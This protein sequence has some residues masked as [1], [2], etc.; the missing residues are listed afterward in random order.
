MIFVQSEATAARRRFPV[1]LVDA[2]DGIT[3]ETG[4]AGGQSQIS[5]NGG[6]FANT[7]ATLTAIGNGAYYVELTATELDTAGDIIVR[8]KSAN[9]AEFDAP[10]DV[11]GSNIHS[12][13]PA[14]NVTQWLGATPN[15]L[16]SGRVDASVGAMA[17]NV[18]TAAA[19]AGDFSTE[20]NSPI[21]AVLG[22]LADAAAD[23]DPTSADTLMQ[24]MKQLVNVL[25]GTAGVV[26]WPAA[27]VPG[28]GV[29]LAEVLRQNYD[30]VANING[31]TPATAAAVAAVQT[32]VDDIQTRLP[33]ALE[34][35]R[36]AAQ[37]SEP[38]IDQI[39]D[40]TWEEVL[41][42]DHVF[43]SGSAGQALYGTLSLPGPSDVADA[44]WD[45]LLSGHAAAGSTGE[46]LAD[47]GGAAATPAD[48]AD[49]V[50]DELLS[51]HLGAGST[52]AALNGAGSAGDPWTTG[53]PGAY[54]VGTAGYIIGQNLNA[55]VGSRATQTSVDAVQADTD[56]L[57]TR[58][59]AALVSGRM[60][61]SVGAMA[62]NVMTAAAADP[63]LT[64]ELQ[65]GLATAAALATVQA[66]TDNMQTRLPAALVGGRMDAS[67]GAVAA[68]AITAAAFAAGAFDAVWTVTTRTL[69]TGALTAATFAAGAFD[70]VWAVAARTLTAYPGLAIPTPA[71]VWAAATRTLTSGDG[72]VLAKGTGVTG[73]NDV[74][75]AEVRDEAAAALEVDT[76]P[77]PTAVPT[78]QASLVEKIGWLQ[79]LARNKVTSDATQIVAR[80]DGDTATVGVAAKS[81]N[82][83][84]YVRGEFS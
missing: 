2:T 65:A 58:I 80:N 84:T 70:A 73:F 61:S 78:A 48:I 9:T 21:L 77:E 30:E 18:L 5:K 43:T 15:A 44:V 36:M 13:V 52:G 55:T 3:A 42:P 56:N 24:Y 39:V 40:E 22:A 62:A 32:D 72:I 28:N 75:A 53:L 38:Q 49:A 50:W 16:I 68:G 83:V 41:F 67:V 59:P 14:V 79:L 17:A 71:D 60:D 25:V 35:G 45:E 4:E 31:A 64:T 63:G 23:G 11:L 8:Y 7:T 57:Q 69:S 6:A 19:T 34:S 47:A 1:F 26:T 54:G 81:D 51:G 12:S 29:S 20:V 37:L 46:A 27:A 74:S 66:D 76:Y 10:G 33:A 82:D